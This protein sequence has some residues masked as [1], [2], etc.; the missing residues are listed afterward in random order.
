M[1]LD[2]MQS[3]KLR[4]RVRL[5]TL[6]E[7]PGPQWADRSQHRV[8]REVVHAVRE[9]S[10][11]SNRWRSP[12]GR[13]ASPRRSVSDAAWSRQRC[14]P[15]PSSSPPPRRRRIVGLGQGATGAEVRAVQQAL[16]SA[17]VPVPGGADGVFGPATKSAVT[18]FQSRNGLAATGTV[19]AATAAAL[20]LAT[21]RR[22][23]RA[24]PAATRSARGCVTRSGA[25][26]VGATGPAVVALQQALMAAGVWLPGGA[27]GV[28][29]SRHDERISNFQS[30][31]GLTVSG[32][33]D[34]ATFARLK[35]GAPAASPTPPAPAP[36]LLRRQPR[37]SSPF[38]GMTRRGPG[39][40]RQ[41]PAAG[42]DRSRHHRS[43][44]RRRRVRRDDDRRAD[45]VTSSPR[46]WLP[47]GVVDDATIAALALVRRRLL[48]R[49]RRPRRRRP[50]SQRARTSD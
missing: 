21:A 25:P 6:V 5:D 4:V 1:L 18:A 20:G 7:A 38:S 49:P 45:H 36:A 26:V 27:D 44:W 41:G 9:S 28:F 8:G 12:V 39:R 42:A 10:E 30:W 3:S 14:P 13:C 31:N 33:V 34:A 37:R 11:A 35:L 17:G 47:S 24:T 23:P 48:R 19:D 15:P 32:V 40:Q 43:R 29:G 16:I 50:R 22:P 2:G 46:V